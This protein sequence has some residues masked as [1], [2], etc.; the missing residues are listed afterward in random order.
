MVCST[1]QRGYTLDRV[2]DIGQAGFDC[3]HFDSKVDARDAV[4]KIAGRMSLIGNVNNPEV[5]L[6]GTPKDAFERVLRTGRRGAGRR[7]R[8]R[9]PVSD[10]DEELEGDHTYSV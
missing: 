9:D 10:A 2:D 3:F 1:S 5:L 4:T 6:H 8:V 7:P